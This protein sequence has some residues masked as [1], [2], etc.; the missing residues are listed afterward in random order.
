[1]G[2]SGSP[3]LSRGLPRPSI[4]GASPGQWATWDDRR[5]PESENADSA[6][7]AHP[8]TGDGP[9]T[10][11]A[12]VRPGPPDPSN[13]QSFQR[14]LTPRGVVILCGGLGTRFARRDRVP[15][16][17]APRRDRCGRP[18]LW[19]IMKIFGHYGLK[20]FTLCLGYKGNLIKGLLPKL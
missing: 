15:D 7:T 11:L 17:K 16:P 9:S 19:H 8:L 18:I 2:I 12:T 5:C 4:S 20:D 1:M 3:R 10:I 6:G 13:G 14:S